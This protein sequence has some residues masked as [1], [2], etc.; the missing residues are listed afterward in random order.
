MSAGS[1]LGMAAAAPGPGAKPIT[2]PG[3][4]LGQPVA[5]P[6]ANMGAAGLGANPMSNFLGVSS[7]GGPAGGQLGVQGV[8]GNRGPQTQIAPPQ[9]GSHGTY[10]LAGKMSQINKPM[11]GPVAPSALNL[12]KPAMGQMPDLRR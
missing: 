4:V 7:V 5:L 11:A 9:I 1:Q 12:N 6:G 3:P 8:L 10:N 2:T